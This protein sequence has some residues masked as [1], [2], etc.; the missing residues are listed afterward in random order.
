M[1]NRISPAVASL[2]VIVMIGAATAGVAN[3]DNK[4]TDE[5]APTNAMSS[6]PSISSTTQATLQGGVYTKKGTYSTPGGTESISLTVTLK[7]DI[8]EDID[9][10]QNANRGDSAIYQS[11]FASGYKPLVQGKDIKQVKLT[12]VAGSSLTSNGFNQALENIRRDA[13]L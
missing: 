5:P 8:I 4:N 7:N 10:Q 11:K 6:Q 12:R 9:L 1:Q 2:I 13:A 3:L